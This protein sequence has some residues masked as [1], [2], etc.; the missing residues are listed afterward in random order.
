[1]A[2]T[3]Q[4]W[5]DRTK[6]WRRGGRGRSGWRTASSK[7]IHIV[8]S[9]VAVDA[10]AHRSFKYDERHLRILN[11][12]FDWMQKSDASH[13]WCND[14]QGALT[15]TSSYMQWNTIDSKYKQY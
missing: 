11:L 3:D 12:E 2:L 1:M 8:H 14:H 7:Q 4:W 13:I 10:E 6:G 15:V 9:D 5:W